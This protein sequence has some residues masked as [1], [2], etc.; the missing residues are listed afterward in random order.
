V[1]SGSL[2]YPLRQAKKIGAMDGALKLLIGGSALLYAIGFGAISVMAAVFIPIIGM[3]NCLS[4]A[5]WSYSFMSR[6]HSRFTFRGI[7]R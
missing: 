5:L 7:A 3:H 6:R 2:K 1:L 4:G